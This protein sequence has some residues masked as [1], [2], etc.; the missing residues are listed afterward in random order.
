MQK[1]KAG[2]TL[3]EIMIV[4]AIIGLLA[5]IAVPSFVRAR[6]TSQ[7]NTC[8]NN[9]RQIDGAKDQWAI[10]NNALTGAAVDAPDIE[11]YLKSEPQCP[12]DDTDAGLGNYVLATVGDNATCA[13]ANAA[14]IITRP[15]LPVSWLQLRNS[16]I[17]SVKLRKEPPVT[18][19]LFRISAEGSFQCGQVAVEA[20]E[21]SAPLLD[22][23]ADVLPGDFVAGPGFQHQIVP[24]Q[25]RRAGDPGDLQPA[26]EGH[27][28]RKSGSS[29]RPIKTS[30]PG[31]ASS[32]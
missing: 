9:L 10:E 19:A 23:G 26:G 7:T 8:I 12:A 24:C 2:F 20:D 22:G 32:S 17:Q 13:V 29:S 27:P 21:G 31:S 15:I 14:P 25:L 6:N 11:A 28:A 1:K 16:R 18:G 30:R 3:V 5:A 4:V